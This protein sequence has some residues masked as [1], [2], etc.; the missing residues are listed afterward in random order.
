MNVGNISAVCAIIIAVLSLA[1]S[2]R[3]ARATREHNRKS[4]RPA[5]QLVRFKTHGDSWCGLLLTNAGLGPAVIVNTSVQLD[6][7]AIGNWDREQFDLLAGSSKSI[8]NFR[9]LLNNAVVPAGGE[10]RLIFIG[11]F[12]KGRD[13]WFWDL[14]NNRIDLEIKYESIYGGEGL[15]E[16][17]RAGRS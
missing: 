15:T 7:K 17:I 11:S 16:A 6:G 14:I 13:D 8:P 12:R 1:T 4:V 9:S 10:S 3:E 2:V 5:L